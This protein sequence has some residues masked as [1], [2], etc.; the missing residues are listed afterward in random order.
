MKRGHHVTVLTAYRGPLNGRLDWV[1]PS[2]WGWRAAYDG[3]EAIYLK[4]RLQYHKATLNPGVMD[5]CRK[6]LREY[7]I[8][9]IY[10]LYDLLGPVVAYF[11]RLAGIPYVVEPM[12]MFR[13]IVQSIRLKRLYH[14]LLG[15]KLLSGAGVL[16]ATI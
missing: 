15:I 13:P 1:E 5:F 3:V 9:H 7:D 14:Q 4:S 12:G 10:G 11:C 6:Q 16:V 8:V 2:P